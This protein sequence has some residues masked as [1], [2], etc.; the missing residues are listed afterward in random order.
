MH[1]DHPLVALDV[2]FAQ[3]DDALR[4]AAI[5]R[6]TSLARGD[7]PSRVRRLRG[8]CGRALIRLGQSLQGPRPGRQAG[9]PA[10]AA[11]AL[12]LAR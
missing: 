1:A 5:A 7:E 8:V 10:A 2:A 4:Q 11:G 9:D 12:H 6:L 3:Q